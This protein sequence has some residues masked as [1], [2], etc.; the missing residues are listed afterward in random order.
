M[1]VMES[2]VE[3]LDATG[4]VAVEKAYAFGDKY[5]VVVSTG[6]F[7]MSCPATTYAFTFDTAGEYVS[8]KAEIDGCSEN[9]EVLTEGNKLTIKKEGKPSIFYN[10]I[11]K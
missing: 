1:N 11:V 9:V 7:G 10:G 2:V 4:Y 8:G 5:L 3:D 6:E